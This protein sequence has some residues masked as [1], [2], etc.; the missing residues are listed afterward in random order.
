[1]VDDETYLGLTATRRDDYVYRI[2]KTRH[3]F[4]LLSTGENVLVRP[5]LWADPFENFILRSHF[6]RNGEPI[7]IGPRDHFYGQCWTFQQASDAMWRIYSPDSG[8]VRLR[9]TIRK[10]VESLRSWRD[11]WADQEVFMG[12]VQYL[13][14]RDL[15]DF[16]RSMLM[17]RQGP[18]THRNLA[19]TLLVKRPA[20]RHE[21]EVRLLFTPHDF[22]RFG[23]DRLRYPAEPNVLIDQV[24][25]DPRMDATEAAN[26]KRQIL[27]AGFKGQ[28]KRSLLYAPPPDLRI[29]W[30]PR[31]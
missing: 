15:I 13:K 24:M 11:H 3:L 12:K 31:D 22:H 16:G 1:M 5:K 9:S 10:L 14:N 20:F 27:A 26:L 21:R 23:D 7:I 19:R 4:D 28:V 25:I 8:A 2:D 18:L 17:G 29:P 6:I 30:E